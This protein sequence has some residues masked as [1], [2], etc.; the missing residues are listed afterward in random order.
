MDQITKKHLNFL[1]LFG[2]YGKHK[3]EVIDS[4][5]NTIVENLVPEI[6]RLGMLTIDREVPKSRKDIDRYLKMPRYEKYEKYPDEELREWIDLIC[7]INVT[8]TQFQHSEKNSKPIFKKITYQLKEG[9]K[10]LL[11]SRILLHKAL[12]E[13]DA[14]CRYFNLWQSSKDQ[15]LDTMKIYKSYEK[16]MPSSMLWNIKKSQEKISMQNHIIQF[17]L[18]ICIYF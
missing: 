10:N 16:R 12:I 7:R 6:F 3:R 17:L 14:F 18:L 2:P 9:V 11:E 13:L 1:E 5:F 15:I 4:S 8:D